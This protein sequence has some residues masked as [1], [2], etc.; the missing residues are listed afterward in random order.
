MHHRSLAAGTL[1]ATAALFSN[2]T[3]SAEHPATPDATNVEHY[4]RAVETVTDEVVRLAERREHRHHIPSRAMSWLREL[5]NRA[6]H[7]YVQ[8][9]KHGDDVRHTEHNYRDLAASYQDA[10]RAE[11]QIGR[12]REVRRLFSQLRANMDGLERAYRRGTWRDSSESALVR[13]LDRGAQRLHRQ[14]ERQLQRYGDL[15]PSQRMAVVQ[16]HR[17][18][19]A[20][21][22]LADPIETRHGRATYALAQVR[23]VVQLYPLVRRSARRANVSPH[24]ERQLRALAPLVRDIARIY[25]IDRHRDVAEQHRPRRRY[26][27]P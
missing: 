4:V 18:A 12:D 27:T 17:F 7:L 3:A 21:R 22:R 26:Y 20:T 16:A 1:L 8:L 13:D 10:L 23:Q 14:I 19:E 5:E 24:L 15:T 2:A 11:H 6:D 9:E 25:E